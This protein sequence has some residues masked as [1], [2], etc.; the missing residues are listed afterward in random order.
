MSVIT[1]P[2]P[3][4]HDKLAVAVVYCAPQTDPTCG[5]A[6]DEMNHDDTIVGQ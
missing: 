6:V 1:I 3:T 2:A 5:D 4:T